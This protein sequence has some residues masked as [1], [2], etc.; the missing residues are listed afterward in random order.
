VYL[1]GAS[2]EM[3]ELTQK[4]INQHRA[5]PS[6]TMPCLVSISEQDGCISPRMGTLYEE[7]Y[8]IFSSLFVRSIRH[9]VYLMSL[10][11]TK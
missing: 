6:V 7:K 1:L 9:R 4:E 5:V 2:S 8:R 3:P 11:A 10:K